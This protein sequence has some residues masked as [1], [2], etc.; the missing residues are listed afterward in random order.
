MTTTFRGMPCCECSARWLPVYEAELLRRGI[1]KHNIDIY[2][3]N[4]SAP[5][6]AGTHKG[7]AADLAQISDEAV[8]VS[9]KMGS[10]AWARPLDWDGDGGMPHQ[11]LVLRGCPHNEAARYQIVALDNGFNGLGHN[12]EGGRDTGPHPY[13]IR[14]W[15]EGIQWAK[16]LQEKEYMKNVLLDIKVA[17][18]NLMEAPR[19][20]D[21][22]M[23]DLVEIQA[24][25][26]ELV[27]TQ[28]ASNAKYKS[29]MNRLTRLKRL[30]VN[31]DPALDTPFMYD[32]AVITPLFAKSAV[33]VHKATS[34]LVAR[35]WFVSQKFRVVGQQG[36]TFIAGDTH[37]IAR[38][39]GKHGGVNRPEDPTDKGTVKQRRAE[40]IAGRD[41]LLV[42]VVRRAKR[43]DP[44]IIGCDANRNKVGLDLP[45]LI[46]GRRV[47]RV[48][49]GLDYLY[50]IDG[51]AHTW[52]LVGEKLVVRTSSDHPV[53]IQ[54]A[55][56]V[57]R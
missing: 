57:K 51:D 33:P 55:R 30:L 26:V 16:G 47:Q 32:P 37:L 4:G 15:R 21:S 50:F 44:Q 53:L 6:S 11:H 49:Q 13:A 38:A 23:A 17:T 18:A 2:Q 19:H 22:L 56:L 14:T 31:T 35:R 9:R 5:A 1:I 24:T 42:P 12:G 8:L 28:E 25:G 52:E 20:D 41:R 46:E 43:G 27:L 7:G 10:A 45:T 3:L 54:R 29:L 40:W 48:R 36:A 39:W 34:P